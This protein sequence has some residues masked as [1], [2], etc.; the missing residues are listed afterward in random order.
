MSLVGI[1]SHVKSRAF[2]RYGLSL[3][4]RKLREIVSLV[5]RG[6]GQCLRNR[7]LAVSEWEIGFE[8]T[9]IR[10]LY[11]THRRAVK[12]FL[13]PRSNRVPVAA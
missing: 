6:K 2:E 10:L 11:D 5:E 8:G 9:I 4:R 12:T 1:N 3:N 7:S 13:P